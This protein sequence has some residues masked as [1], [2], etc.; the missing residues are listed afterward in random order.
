M[1]VKGS[2]VPSSPPEMALSTEGLCVQT[3]NLDLF[4][5]LRTFS[6]TKKKKTLNTLSLK[7]EDVCHFVAI[8]FA[9][10]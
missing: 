7:C 6:I 2:V 10:D 1:M 4:L 3:S 9:P 5:F 8:N